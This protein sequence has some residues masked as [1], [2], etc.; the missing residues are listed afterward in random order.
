MTIAGLYNAC[1]ISGR[2]VIN[3]HGVLYP[4]LMKIDIQHLVT[5]AKWNLEAIHMLHI[6]NCAVLDLQHTGAPGLRV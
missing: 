6:N 1:V 5:H 3:Q 2:D 4:G